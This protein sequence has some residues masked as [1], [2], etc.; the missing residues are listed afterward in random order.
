[1][2]RWYRAAQITILALALILAAYESIS[3]KVIAMVAF[4]GLLLLIWV[5]IKLSRDQRERTRSPT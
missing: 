5:L 2:S 1:V 3:G 4:A